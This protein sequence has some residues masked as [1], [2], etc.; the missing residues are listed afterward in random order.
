MR[1][2]IVGLPNLVDGLIADSLGFRHGARGPSLATFRGAGCFVKDFGAELRT[3]T[4]SRMLL[5][6]LKWGAGVPPAIV[7]RSMAGETPA[8]HERLQKSII[9]ETLV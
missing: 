2:D 1:L 7:S 6:F 5:D 9:L 3:D 8:L 4:K